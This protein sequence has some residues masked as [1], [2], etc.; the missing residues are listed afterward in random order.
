MTLKIRFIVL[1]L[2]LLILGPG[3]YFYDTVTTPSLPKPSPMRTPTPTM[4]TIY[5]Y[6]ITPGGVWSAEQAGL[7]G[8]AVE[9]V[10]VDFYAYVNYARGGR[11][12]WTRRPILIRAG[13]RV[14]TDGHKTI[15]ARCGNTISKSPQVPI[16]TQDISTMLDEPVPPEDT[17]ARLVSF[18]SSL[19]PPTPEP[20]VKMPIPG[21][22]TGLEG[23]GGLSGGFVPVSVTPTP[24]RGFKPK[25]PG[26]GRTP[27]P[28]PVPPTPV[29]EPGSVLL[30][31]T[32]AL[33]LYFGKRA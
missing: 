16:E 13:E 26:K 27:E 20:S 19:T 4:H 22:E 15:R 1:M 11:I 25:G 10:R 12:W 29:P 9:T 14:V 32:G 21:P 18:N 17:I 33:I 3:L 6:S 24:P 7:P 30:F 2:V 28:P 31:A 5:K 8:A 23:S